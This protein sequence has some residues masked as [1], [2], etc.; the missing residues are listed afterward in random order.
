MTATPEWQ[1]C[2]RSIVDDPG[3]VVVIG[4]SDAGK[5]TFSTELLNAAVDA[6]VKCA[7]VDAD[8]GQSEIGPP[9]TIGLGIPTSVVERPSEIPV[10]RLHFTGTTSP[11]GNM[12]PSVVGVRKMADEARALGAR[13]I[14][15]DTTGFVRGVL[16]KKLKTMKVDLLTPRHII[17]IQRA[18]E[19]EPII[20]SFRTIAGTILHRLTV[21]ERARL[22]SPELRASRRRG[23]FL[24]HFENAEEHVIRLDDVACWGTWLNTGRPFPWQRVTL[25]EKMLKVRILH[26]ETTGQGYYVALESLPPSNVATALQER[27]RTRHVSIVKGGAFTYA[28][29]GLA[30]N[31]GRCLNVG[32]IHAID[33]RQRHVVVLTPLKSVTPVRIIQFG[34]MRVKPDGTELARLR[35]GEI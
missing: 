17:A 18:H 13:L 26:A 31:K 30:D 9:G 29:V 12:L 14:V 4:A 21:S 2:I 22:K 32:I 23:R 10:R 6:G 24:R 19:I 28:Y 15:V 3:P 11:V 35:P 8:V 1:D 25:L 33:F 7:L 16:A 20:N 27:L 5:T 34:L